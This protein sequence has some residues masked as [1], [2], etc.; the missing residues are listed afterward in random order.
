MALVLT[1]VLMT[2]MAVMMTSM[3]AYTSAAARDSYLKQSE[4]SAHSLAEA[5][6]DQ[7]TAQLA[8]HYYDSTN[9]AVNGTD[10]FSPSWFTDS[11]LQQEQ[12][13]PIS[14]VGCSG[15]TT[16]MRWSIASCSF[17]TVVPGCTITPGVIGITKGTVVLR[18]EGSVPNPTGGA[19]RSSTVTTKLDVSQPPADVK[20]PVY[21]KGIYAGA[22]SNATTCDLNLGQ[23]VTVGAPLY[24]AGNLCMTSSSQVFGADTTVKVLGWAWLRQ[25]STIGSNTGSPARVATAQIKGGCS[26]GGSQPTM[27]SGCTI[28]QNS[29]AIWDNTPTA[30]HAATAPTP[31]PLPT[32]DWASVQA[33]QNTTSPFPTCTNGRAL[34]EA[35]FA[36]F[37]GASYTCTSAVGSI[38]YTY[39]S[40]G[41]STLQISGII[42]FAGNVSLD[43]S[44]AIKY[45]GIGGLFVAGSAFASNNSV[46]C[47]KLLYGS[48]DFTNATNTGS[49]GFWDTTQSVMLLQSQGAFNAANFRFQGGIYSA[50]SIT[51]TGGQSNTQGPLV[52]PGQLTVGQQLD[53]SFPSFPVIP[54]GS[55][56]TDPPP[57]VLGKPYGSS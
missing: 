22:T 51:V 16:C 53:G 9:T 6:L 47:V 35:T 50:T 27:T 18:G 43:T 7:A 54:A 13:S 1:M 38:A 39:V 45:S 42:Y 49:S 3:L 29:K 44:G 37:P 4:Q 17:A 20:T 2:V 10:A 57:Y 21:W 36:L 24:V 34:T 14:G 26:S 8:S 5:A 11:T 48:C 33:R 52:T 55:L 31:D 40:G 12:Q 19:R 46:V 25:S 15:T 23:G 56:G 28:N 30:A 32:I 41:T